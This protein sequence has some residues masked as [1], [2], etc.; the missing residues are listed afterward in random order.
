MKQARKTTL[1]LTMETEKP[2]PPKK[3]AKKTKKAAKKTVKK[4]SRPTK[5][6]KASQPTKE[7]SLT[8]L[9]LRVCLR[10]LT[11]LT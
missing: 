5:I 10:I 6:A 2:P 11:S 7:L 8:P 4:P 1:H 3:K 9:T